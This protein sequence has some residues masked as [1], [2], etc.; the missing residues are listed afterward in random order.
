MVKA[1][2]K[3]RDYKQERANMLHERFNPEFIKQQEKM[4]KER[5]RKEQQ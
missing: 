1:V 5:Q 3:T 4:A 2:P